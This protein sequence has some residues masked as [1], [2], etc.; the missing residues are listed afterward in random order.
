MNRSN[1][2]EVS[3]QP[4]SLKEEIKL[5][6]KLG[7]P[8]I[9]SNL[10]QILLPIIDGIMV[11]SIHSNQ[12]AAAS[13]VVNIVTIPVILCMGLPM[14][15]SPL[16][17]AALGKSDFDS[18]AKL[19]FNGIIVSGLLSLCLALIFYFGRDLIFHLGQDQEIAEIA[20]GYFVIIGW[21]L[22]P[23]SLF[24]VFVQF[25]SGL[26]LTKFV[27]ILSFIKV[28][29]NIFLNYILIF[30]HFGMPALELLGA[31]YGT[32]LTQIITLL[33]FVVVFLHSQVFDKYRNNLKEALQIR[34]SIMRKIVKIGLPTGL[35]IALESGAFAF[36]GIMAGWI[37][38]QQQAAHQIGLYI[39]SLTLMVP[40]GICAAG[41]IRIGFNFGK[42]DWEA[43]NSIGRTTLF[44]AILVSISFSLF[45]FF[46]NDFISRLFISELEVV[47]LAKM[48]LLMV[49]VFQ[50]SDAIQTTSSGILR[51]IQ[52]VKVPAYLS[53]IAFWM[54]GIPSAYLL[55]FQMNW[56]VSG[57]WMGLVIGL[58]SN[59][60]LLTSRFFTKVRKES[61][62]ELLE[63]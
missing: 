22:I 8:I 31:G 39:S 9:V 5:T 28:P 25:A 36:S 41:T 21:R 35:L 45:L 38:A 2:I 4:K 19:L 40:L 57:L 26:G 18:P 44:L 58:T 62:K 27:M 33:V 1:T 42:K 15:L 34:I 32:F 23:L 55:S 13:L 11:G 60:I 56:G 6:M 43:I 63:V 29:I 51:G 20:Q 24:V 59:A 30:G 52:D 10:T 48:V 37:G 50:I 3:S 17:S 7:W 49:A 47:Q 54:I 53:L 46:G 61:K 12:L 16:V 14:A